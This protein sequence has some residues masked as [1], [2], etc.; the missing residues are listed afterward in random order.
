MPSGL[1][2][3]HTRT[4]TGS[5]PGASARR[6]NA[7]PRGSGPSARAAEPAG[8]YIQALFPVPPGRVL[9]VLPAA[10]FRRLPVC[11]K[12]ARCAR[13]TPTGFRSAGLLA[14]GCASSDT[15]SRPDGGT[16]KEER[17]NSVQL[18]GRLTRDPELRET[19]GGTTV[20]RMGLAISRRERDVAPVYVEVKAFNAQAKSCGEFLT[21]GRE[22]AVTGRLETDK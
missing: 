6:A 19:N 21:K 15:D 14:A 7:W 20:C 5:D 12:A 9:G 2:T 22:V 10:Q 1:D 18:I 3:G 17:M 8:R 13:A 11:A 16:Q 4:S